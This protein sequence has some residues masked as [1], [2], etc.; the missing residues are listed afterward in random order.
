MGRIIAFASGKGGTG[1]TTVIANVA[2]AAS[3]LGKDVGV[4]DADIPMANLALVLG[5]GEQDTTIHEVLAG[6]SDLSEAIYT[7]AEGVKAVPSGMSLN[8]V[9]KA[10]PKGVKDVVKE[11]SDEVEILLIDCPSGLGEETLMA[12]QLAEELVLVVMPE[13]T[14]LSDAL[15]TKI[16]AKRFGVETIGAIISRASEDEDLDVAFQEVESMLETSVLGVIPEDPEIRKSITYGE[17]VVVRKPKSP[18]GK[19]I[20]KIVS[21]LFKD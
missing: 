9:R 2:V 17:P 3:Q 12:L 18:S 4:L 11:F 16:V 15:K 20:Q 5:L 7:G 1:K 13:I 21:E 10:D 14:S 19:G 8:G 6:E